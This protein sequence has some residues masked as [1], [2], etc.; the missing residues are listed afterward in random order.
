MQNAIFD[1]EIEVAASGNKI[2]K[3]NGTN[4]EKII[5]T[6]LKEDSELILSQNQ[7]ILYVRTYDI[8]N[9]TI[10]NSVLLIN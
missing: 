6:D 5:D 8:K 1:A 2:Y 7:K 3:F 4:F 9:E 10:Y